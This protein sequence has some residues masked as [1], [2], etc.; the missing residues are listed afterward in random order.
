MRLQ[1]PFEKLNVIMPNRQIHLFILILAIS[2]LDF[3]I[4]HWQTIL[5]QTLKIK[6]K[7]N[8]IDTEVM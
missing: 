8:G 6:N 2:L 7:L 4:A 1:R 5:N 3:R